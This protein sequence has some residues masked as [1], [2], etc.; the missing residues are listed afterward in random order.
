M[1]YKEYD[2]TEND[3][4]MGCATILRSEKAALAVCRK[5]Y[6]DAKHKKVVKWT[7]PDFGPKDDKDLEGNARSLY[8]NGE[9]PAKGYIEPEKVSWIWSDD[10]CDEGNE[11]KFLIGGTAGEECQQ[12]D[13]GDC[14][15]VSALSI[16]AN[17]DELIIGGMKGLDYD[18]DMIVD[19]EIA[20]ALS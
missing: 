17:R 16:V 1:S 11:S 4:F 15:F 8:N 18:P 19:K 7:D 14:W 20:R 3:Y 6:Q 13:L 12:G 5:L 9:I 10:R 2:V